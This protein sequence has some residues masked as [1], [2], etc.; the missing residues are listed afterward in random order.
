MTRSGMKSFESIPIIKIVLTSMYFS[1]DIT[2]IVSELN[3]KKEL[4]KFLNIGVVPTDNEI[5][6]FMSKFEPEQFIDFTFSLLNNICS[7]TSREGII[8]DSTDIVLDLNWFTRRITKKSLENRDFKWGYS[9]HRGYFVGMKMTLALEY[10]TLKPLAF[11]INESNVS[12]SKI[13]TQILDELKRR[14]ILRLGEIVYF[15]RGYYS[16]NN[17]VKDVSKFKIVPA[18][19]PKANCNFNK[20]SGM[21]SYPLHIFDSKKNVK[22]EMEIYRIIVAKLFSLLENWIGLK[23]IRSIIEDVF[24]LAKNKYSLSI[25]HRYTRRSAKKYCCLDVL[26][27]GL[28]V[29]SGIDN[30]KALQKLAEY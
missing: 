27:V 13:Y 23:P 16:Y 25:L 6:R 19:F 14:R 12:E 26:L 5:Y 15:D 7:Q 18:I 21:L 1:S 28:T 17:Y 24:K 3:E 30:K 29:A 20:L 22:K 10:S 9:P 4:R 8:V 2:Y 11:I